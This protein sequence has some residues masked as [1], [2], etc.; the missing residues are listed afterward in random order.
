MAAAED[1]IALLWQH[2]DSGGLM[3][4]PSEVEAV[5]YTVRRLAPYCAKLTRE[6]A[7]GNGLRPD[8]VIRLRGLS[9]APLA[10]ELKQFRE[11]GMT[12]FPEAV[13]QAASYA[14]QLGTAAFIAPLAGKGAA[15][16][17]WHVSPIGTGLLIAGQFGVGG[18][19]FAHE[20]YGDRPCGGLLLAGVQVASFRR[21]ENGEPE[22][23]LHSNAAHLIKLKHGHG[24]ASWRQ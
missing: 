17:E 7:I 20:R 3:P 8:L 10:I 9:D 19:Y 14:R 23:Q 4:F 22:T 11:R 13:R 6:P 1:R 18:L 15:K 21:D 24:S 16:F 2:P 5:E 12:P